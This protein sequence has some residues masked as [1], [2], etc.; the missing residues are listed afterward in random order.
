M[1]I[2]T[3]L[4]I[5]GP[6]ASNGG[7]AMSSTP[8]QPNQPT[9]SDAKSDDTVQPTLPTTVV[10]IAEAE[11]GDQEAFERLYR[12]NRAWLC[13]AAAYLIGGHLARVDVED[14]LQ[15]TFAYV[16]QR[17]QRGEFQLDA[18]EGAF[19]RYLGT[20]LRNK[21]RDAARWAKAKKRDEGREKAMAD[22]YTSTVSQL[23][24]PAADP[25]PS[26][27]MMGN[28]L[29][30]AV[31]KAIASLSEQERK[32]L[33]YR[34][35]CKMSYEEILPHLTM[36]KNG[37]PVLDQEGKPVPV[38][39]VGTAKSMFS[40]A[41]QKL[42]EMLKQRGLVEQAGQAGADAGAEAGEQA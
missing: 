17:V 11:E 42:L 15:E 3:A 36:L 18:T 39:K 29:S 25:T 24:F 33:H 20:V 28:E 32:I 40:R 31:A 1:T 6:R 19:R 9:S 35:V 41:R 10:L 34:M 21:A 12:K 13:A 23:G 38:T 37:E 27:H 8:S 30:S 7:L 14:L 22:L 4:V 2:Q 5:S 26:Q 16:F